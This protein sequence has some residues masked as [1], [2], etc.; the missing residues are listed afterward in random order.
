MGGK[1]LHWL[2]VSA[3][4]PSSFSDDLCIRL[5]LPGVFRMPQTLLRPQRRRQ[6]LPPVVADLDFDEISPFGL[7]GLQRGPLRLLKSDCIHRLAVTLAL[8]A[9]RQQISEEDYVAEVVQRHHDWWDEYRVV[10]LIEKS[11]WIRGQSDLVMTL[12]Q[13][14]SQIPDDPPPAITKILSRAYTVHPEAN[15]WY[16]VPLFGEER[17]EDGLPIP[18]TAVEVRAEARR[19]IEAAQQEAL[20]WG[21]A[22]RAAF[23]AAQLPAVC[24]QSISGR[25]SQ[26]KSYCVQHYRQA[27]ADARR[28]AK[29]AIQAQLQECRTGRS[30][31]TI[32][33]HTTSLGWTAA[34]TLEAF[35]LA[36]SLVGY[37]APAAGT[38][39]VPL[40]VSQIV[41]MFLVPITIV[42]ADPFLFIELPE[43]PG[44]LRHLGHWYWQEQ[45]DGRKKLHLH[46]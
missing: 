31:T 26:A 4:P 1:A 15:V 8:Q 27:R 2:P 10:H 24:V 39:A 7:Q 29:A 44:K 38:A 22:Y 21:W 34:K 6:P 5:P 11:L 16:G 41:P 20:R 18:L 46:T 13:N 17:T 3:E 19:R 33:A 25:I 28:R 30:W 23:R 36:Q 43:E 12:I 37:T 32:P 42:A 40:L 35:F 9:T 14:P 45:A